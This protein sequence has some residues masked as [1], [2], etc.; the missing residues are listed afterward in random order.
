[1]PETTQAPVVTPNDNAVNLVNSLKAFEQLKALLDVSQI[2]GKF[3]RQKVQLD[4]FL[5]EI[6]TNTLSEIRKDPKAMEIYLKLG[7]GNGSNSRG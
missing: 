4:R 5:D 1:M 6:L 7:G 3:C 2:P